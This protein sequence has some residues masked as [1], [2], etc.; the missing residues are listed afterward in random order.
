MQA[1]SITSWLRQ[2]RS[3]TGSSSDLVNHSRQFADRAGGYR[4][5][6]SSDVL[7]WMPMGERTL[8]PDAGEVVLDQ[9]MAEGRSGLVMVFRPA[10]EWSVCPGC[11]QAS[12]RI[13]SRYRRRLNDLPWEGIP[14]R[15]E[16]RVR[17]FFCE[18]ENCGRHIFT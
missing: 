4:R 16:H 5:Q 13:H 18:T 3:K 7:R 17:R 10:G 12:R 8:V 6:I 9:M 1:R 11:R 2:G 15:I 14:V